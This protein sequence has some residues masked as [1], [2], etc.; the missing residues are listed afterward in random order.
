MEDLD[1][2]RARGTDDAR[3]L[4][5][6]PKPMR[7]VLGLENF[8]ILLRRKSGS[9]ERPG[10]A[11]ALVEVELGERGA[12]DV[13]GHLLR[14]LEVAGAHRDVVERHD[15]RPARRRSITGSRRMRWLDHQRGRLLEIHV[16][17]AGDDRRGRAAAPP[18]SS[19]A[20]P[21]GEHVDRRGRGR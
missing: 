12:R 8:R 15:A 10:S 6:E 20:A 5:V 11:A 7:E 1:G 9:S 16:G 3:A 19:V 21:L 18:A 2:Q 17:L 4:G 14:D 13:G